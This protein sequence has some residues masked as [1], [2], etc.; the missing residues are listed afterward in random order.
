ME[1]NICH[2]LV[3]MIFGHSLSLL[4]GQ[5][6][7]FSLPSYPVNLC[8]G[9]VSRLVPRQLTWNWLT[10]IMFN[11]TTICCKSWA[12]WSKVSVEHV[13]RILMRRLN[14]IIFLVWLWWQEDF[15][16]YWCLSVGFVCRSVW[17]WLLL[18]CRSTSRKGSD[19]CKETGYSWLQ[20]YSLYITS[21]HLYCFFFCPLISFPFFG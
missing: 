19:W 3:K 5:A 2:L 13:C 17:I 9:A 16:R 15:R 1:G 10:L 11:L 21:T 7:Y 8:W 12:R 20:L 6:S 14:G 18:T 4:L